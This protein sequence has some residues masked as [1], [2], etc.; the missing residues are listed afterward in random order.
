MEGLVAYQS[1]SDSEEGEKSKKKKEKKK[2]KKHKKEQEKE[3]NAA[4]KALPSVADL[5]SS[6]KTPT[7]LQEERKE[8]EIE[9]IEKE[10]SSKGEKKA[11]AEEGEQAKDIQDL[12]RQVQA[13]E[14]SKEMGRAGRPPNKR[15]GGPGP[16]PF[17]GLHPWAATGRAA[18]RQKAIKEQQKNKVMKGQTFEGR[19]WKSEAEMVMRQS[20]DS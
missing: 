5:L 18:K 4:K 12:V 7:F 14:S 20:F 1:G 10:E 19:T 3:G 16:D 6:A 15:E 13:R 9:T 8:A 17:D 2:K 11:K